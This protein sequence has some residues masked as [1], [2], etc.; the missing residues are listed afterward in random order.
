MLVELIDSGNRPCSVPQTVA[1]ELQ[2]ISKATP[3]S[4]STEPSVVNATVTA[5]SPSQYEVSYTAVSRG[6]YKLHIQVNDREI[7]ESPTITVYPDPNQ[8]AYPV[9]I[10]GGLTTPYS[11]G[12]TSDGE[13]IVSEKVKNQISIFNTK[14]KRI[15]EFEQH[16]DHSRKILKPQGIAIDDDDNVYV[17]SQFKLQKFTSRGN[18][19]HCVGQKGSKERDFNGLC[20]ITLHDNQLY[21]CDCNN[22]RIQVFDLDLN[23]IRSIGSHGKGKCEF[24]RPYDVKFDSD[25]N[26]YVAEWK[27][28][29]VQV[30]D[31]NGQ[32]IRLFDENPT[33]IKAS[34]LHIIDKYVYVSDW[35]RGHILV[36][37]TTGR[38]VTLF[39]GCGRTEGK[40]EYPYC[41]NSYEDQ[42]YICDSDNGRIQTF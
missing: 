15:G 30:L 32:F 38:F 42:V 25:H 4:L 41:I 31:K 34:A 19:I 28:G 27:G 36:Y 7:E 8:L 6:Q 17:S 5:I 11:V 1:A 24:D 29:R 14:G 16:E 35:S 39:G 9:S 3:T 26:M 10:L 37:E 22:H 20:G 2:F 23:F 33:L 40:F 12:F 18:F 21:V 13:M